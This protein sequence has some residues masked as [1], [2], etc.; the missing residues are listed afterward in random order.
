VLEDIPIEGL[1][2][3]Q[4]GTMH[5]FESWAAHI[6]VP[7]TNICVVVDDEPN[8]A[9][10]EA[11]I[12]QQVGYTVYVAHSG[13]QTLELVDKHRPDLVMLD[14][15]MP[16]MNGL[17][18]L[19]RIRETHPNTYVIIVTGKG[20]EETA[21]EVMKAGASDY[22]IKPLPKLPVVRQIVD[23][24]LRLRDAELKSQV[25]V[26]QLR[27]LNEMLEQRVR[28]KT[29]ELE[30]QNLILQRMVVRDDLTGLFNQKAL[31]SRLE[32]ELARSNRYFRRL[33]FIMMDLDIFKQVNDQYGHQIGSDTLKAVAQVILGSIRSV[34][35]AARFGGDEFCIVLPET[36]VQG[37]R[38]VADRVRMNIEGRLF[39]QGPPPLRLTASLGMS[40]FEPGLSPDTL[41]KRA[42]IALYRAKAGGRNRV[43]AW[44]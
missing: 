34:D 24:T 5:D 42:D 3:P 32:Q 15:M 26:A 2:D 6:A 33:G 22:I 29:E 9:K 39:H 17:A 19:Q 25:Y 8:I 16:T 43:E 14:F 36:D 7:H 44:R 13:E 41:V 20:S 38:A 21:I 12:M 23:R 11:M 1:E 10:I 18:V 35:W 31:Y 28:E 27:H 37:T 4:P 30:R 40:V